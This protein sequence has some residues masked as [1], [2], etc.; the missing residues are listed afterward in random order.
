MQILRQHI[1]SRVC[2]FI[3]W[4]GGADVSSQMGLHAG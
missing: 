1:V 2:E 3:L 4:N